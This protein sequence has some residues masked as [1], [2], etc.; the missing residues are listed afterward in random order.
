MGAQFKLHYGDLTDTSDLT[1]L[2]DDIE[3]DEVYNLG[4]QSHVAVSFEAP[5]YTADVDAVGTLRLLEEFVFLDWN[6]NAILSGIYFGTL[7][8]GPR[9]T[10]AR[11]DTFL[12]SLTI[13]SC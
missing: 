7:W 11:N 8:S 12:S 6:K 5:E 2:I 10:S 3:P 4:A 13:C 9:N 1:R